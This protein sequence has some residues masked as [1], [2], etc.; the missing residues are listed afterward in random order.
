[1]RLLRK[2]RPPVQKWTTVEG[3]CLRP[4]PPVPP[5]ARS[6][7][8]RMNFKEVLF[9]AKEGDL[10]D[11]SLSIMSFT[12]IFTRTN[13][14]GEATGEDDTEGGMGELNFTEF[15]SLLGRIADAKYPPESRGGGG[16]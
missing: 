8:S 1:M 6:G 12:S 15:I 13:A 9:L 7:W 10:L 5:H 11:E 3:A 16:E 14:Y 2:F 4:R